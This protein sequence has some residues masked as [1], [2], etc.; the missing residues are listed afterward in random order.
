M[1][2]LQLTQGEYDYLARAVQRDVDDAASILLGEEEPDADA[3]Y[4]HA[5]R[6]LRLLKRVEQEQVAPF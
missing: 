6:M 3:E 4:G 5:C 1:I 2:T